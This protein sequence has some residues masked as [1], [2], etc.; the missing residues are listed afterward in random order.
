MWYNLYPQHSHEGSHYR[1]MSLTFKNFIILKAKY[2]NSQRLGVVVHTHN[3]R[4]PGAEV[5]GPWSE[6][7]LNKRVRTC[8][9]NKQ[10]QKD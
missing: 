2:K 1:R 10:K 4:Y 5:G 3:S 6:T 9:K 7:S 8:L